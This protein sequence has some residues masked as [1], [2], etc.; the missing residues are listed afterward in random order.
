MNIHVAV[1]EAEPL[2]EAAKERGVLVGIIAPGTVRAVTHL[3]VSLDDVRRA[4]E[5]LVEAIASIP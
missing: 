4:G 5:R 2:V 3:D 1:S